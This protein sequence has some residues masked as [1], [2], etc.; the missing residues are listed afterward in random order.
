MAIEQIL[1]VFPG[2]AVPIQAS[3]FK[4]FFSGQN[5]VGVFRV[6]WASRQQDKLCR[7][8]LAHPGVYL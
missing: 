8:G 5:V 4:L 1:F 2:L 6:L 3:Y 7:I